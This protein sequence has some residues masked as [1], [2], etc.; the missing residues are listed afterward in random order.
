ML[1][2]GRNLDDDA[3]TGLDVFVV[4]D[5]GLGSAAVVDGEPEPGDVGWREGDERNESEQTKE[6]V[7][8]LAGLA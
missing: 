3:V 4:G 8:G 6:T 7:P 1:L 2:V 5:F